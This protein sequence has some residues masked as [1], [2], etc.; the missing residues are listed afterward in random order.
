M[1]DSFMFFIVI[2]YLVIIIA[3]LFMIYAIY[4]VFWYL[5]NMIWLFTKIKK[6]S[7]T[8]AVVQFQRNPLKIIFGK[9]GLPDI[10]IKADEKDQHHFITLPS[11][12]DRNGTRTKGTRFKRY[13]L[14]TFPP[15]KYPGSNPHA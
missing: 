13:H 10:I 7:K 3:S 12:S 1:G 5:I 6:I 14:R 9:K 4:K 8:H 15:G 2:K 11:L